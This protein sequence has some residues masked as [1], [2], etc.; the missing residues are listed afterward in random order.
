MKKQRLNTLLLRR[1]T[2]LAPPVSPPQQA[3]YAIGYCCQQRLTEIPGVGLRCPQCGKTFG[4]HDPLLVWSQ[5]QPVPIPKL[6][7]QQAA[8]LKQI[9]NELKEMEAELELRS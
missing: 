5:D 7:P 3:R 8:E 9:D 1:N 6:T 2:I 4:P